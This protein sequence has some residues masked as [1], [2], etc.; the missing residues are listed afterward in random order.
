MK[1]PHDGYTIP[2]FLKGVPGLY[3]D[4]RGERRPMLRESRDAALNDVNRAKGAKAT[5]AA[6][7]KVC[8]RMLVSWTATKAHTVYGDKQWETEPPDLEVLPI[9]QESFA[10]LEP[11]L[12]DRIWNVVMGYRPGDNPNE[13]K[14]SKEPES[15]FD[16][17][18]S[19]DERQAADEKNSAA[20]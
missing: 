11:D 1:D 9:D 8:K 10:V 5:L 20:G 4:L 14:A 3:S 2:F 19:D 6:W 18:L 15:E 13:E 16:A 17:S 7:D 12:W